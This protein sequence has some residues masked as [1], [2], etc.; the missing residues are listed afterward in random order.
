[1]LLSSVM[2]RRERQGFIGTARGH[3]SPKKTIFINT[4]EERPLRKGRQN[5]DYTGYDT[6][7]QKE[8]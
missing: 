1:M 2:E 4:R 7:G 3:V 8:D 6:K 5:I